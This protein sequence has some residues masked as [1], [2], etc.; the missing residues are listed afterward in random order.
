[1]DNMLVTGEVISEIV[2]YEPTKTLVSYQIVNV[3][4]LLE[5]Y[6]C[7]FELSIVDCSCHGVLVNIA[8]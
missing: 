8:T 3:L 5:Q 6:K 2:E 1:M 4:N 7:T